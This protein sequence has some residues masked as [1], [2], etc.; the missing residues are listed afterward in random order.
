MPVQSEARYLDDVLK[1]EEE[2]MRSREAITVLSGEKLLCGQVIGKV[3]KVLGSSSYSGTGNGTIGTISL[4]PQAKLGNYKAICTLVIANSG[5]FQVIDPDGIGLADALAGTAFTSP[6]INFTISDGSTDFAL[7]DTFTI[8]VT[9]GSL[10]AKKISFTAVDGTQDA[11]G[12][13]GDDYDASAADLKGF[14]IVREAVVSEQGLRWPVA[15]TSGGTFEVKAGHAITGAT[16]TKTAKVVRVDLASGTWAGGD[17]AGTFIVEALSGDF[18]AENVD[19]GTNTNV[20]TVAAT[21]SAAALAQ[22][23]AKYILTRKE[24]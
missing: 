6:Q 15:F 5:R 21:A 7:G 4:G 17:A 24:V 14:A 3:G 2:D 13:I 12:V 16:S 10:K 20:A 11:A 8:P 9:V 23:A 22:L 18:Q 1:F 19:V